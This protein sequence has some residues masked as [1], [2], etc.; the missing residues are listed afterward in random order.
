MPPL[1]RFSNSRGAC[2]CCDGVRKR[3][4]GIDERDEALGLR[5]N[6]AQQTDLLAHQLYG[7]KVLFR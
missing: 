6:L 2:G 3:I 5:R 1:D 4:V 7:L